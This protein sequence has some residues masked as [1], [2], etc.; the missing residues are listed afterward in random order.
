MKQITST[1]DR[2]DLSV[3]VWFSMEHF[4]S[5]LGCV[6]VLKVKHAVELF[7]EKISWPLRSYYVNSFYMDC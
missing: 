4:E 2:E 5:L 1:L 7:T 6:N 3:G